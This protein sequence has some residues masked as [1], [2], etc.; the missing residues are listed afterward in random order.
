MGL[1]W[2]SEPQPVVKHPAHVG[3]TWTDAVDETRDGGTTPPPRPG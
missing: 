3:Y 2:N 1:V